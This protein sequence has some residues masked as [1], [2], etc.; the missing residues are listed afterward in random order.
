MWAKWTYS[1]DLVRLYVKFNT[2]YD[3]SYLRKAIEF[4]V[5]AALSIERVLKKPAP[6]CMLTAFGATSLEYEL[7]FW[8]KD[9]AAGVA[10]VKS[11]VLLALWDTLANEGVKIRKPGPARG[12]IYELAREDEPDAP[13][14]DS[15]AVASAAFAVSGLI[16]GI[17]LFRSEVRAAG[18]ALFFFDCQ[19]L[20]WASICRR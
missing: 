16:A 11:D 19:S 7:W 3:S 17:E 2:T 9:P 4:A 15:D 8:I 1:S 5:A 18:F 6:Q 20:C 14:D 12:M 10:N 13:E